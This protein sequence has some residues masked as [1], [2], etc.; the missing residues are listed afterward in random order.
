[1]D[2]MSAMEKMRRAQL[3]LRDDEELR[4]DFGPA[5]V[6]GPL[7]I[8][9]SDPRGP[10]G[11][12][13]LGPDHAPYTG[14][15]YFY[16]FAYMREFPAYANALGYAQDQKSRQIMRDFDI[17]QVDNFSAWWERKGEDLFYDLYEDESHAIEVGHDTKKRDLG[18]GLL[19]YL[20]I[21]GNIADMLNEV[22]HMFTRKRRSL[23]S[24][25][26]ELSRKYALHQGRYTVSSLHNKLEIYRA[27][28][29]NANALRSKEIR[30]Y[31]IFFQLADKLIISRGLRNVSPDAAS[32]NMGESFDQACRLLYHIGEGRFPDY[33]LPPRRYNPR[34]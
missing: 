14:N 13:A 25:Y 27:V 6:I 9:K 29:A 10:S 8:G 12:K 31:D 28:M 3:G 26:P 2:N 18:D 24:R 22:E 15:V 1:M 30:L 23:S 16:W 7:P 32:R 20:P 33:S 4:D 17:R 11:N 19:V 34:T 21:D 5:P